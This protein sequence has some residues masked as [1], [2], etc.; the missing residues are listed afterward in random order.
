MSPALAGGF[1]TTEPVGESL[2]LAVLRI[3]GWCSVEC[4]SVGICLMLFSVLDSGYGWGRKTAEEGAFSS[5][6]NASQGDSPLGADLD[7]LACVVFVGFFT[8]KSP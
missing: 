1:F 6:Q 5:H 7:C 4:H 8:V 3:T 2:A